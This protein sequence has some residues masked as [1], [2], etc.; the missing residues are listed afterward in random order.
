[1]ANFMGREETV[2]LNDMV[3]RKCS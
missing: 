2:N 3:K 1:M